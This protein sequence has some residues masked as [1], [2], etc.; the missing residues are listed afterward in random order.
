M[1]RQGRVVPG[2]QDVLSNAIRAVRIHDLLARGS[3]A[4]SPGLGFRILFLVQYERLHLNLD[5]KNPNLCSPWTVGMGQSA[6]SE[7]LAVSTLVFL[8][9]VRDSSVFQTR[10][11]W[12]SAEC[13]NTTP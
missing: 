8:G 6:C 11:R 4:I 9:C 12:K 2:I 13:S 10:E 5:H 7:L 3:G 1:Y